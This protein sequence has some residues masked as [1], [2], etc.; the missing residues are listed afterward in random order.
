MKQQPTPDQET[1]ESAKFLTLRVNAEAKALLQRA[2]RRVHAAKFSTGLR[3]LALTAAETPAQYPIPRQAG[4]FARGILEIRIYVSEEEHLQVSTAARQAGYRWTSEWLLDLFGWAVTQGPWASLERPNVG[5][6]SIKELPMSRPAAART[7]LGLV[8][9]LPQNKGGAGKS[10]T[11]TNV[12]AELALLGYESV[13]VDLDPQ[14]D[15]SNSL[16]IETDIEEDGADLDSDLPQR[17]LLTVLVG[18]KPS[19]L[20]LVVPTAW[21]LLH[22]QSG[23]EHT[24]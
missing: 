3:T 22:E 2:V 21:Y 19:L 24:R 18:K 13:L 20:D 5:L 10:T 8:I 4:V 7:P 16:G 6:R 15:L 11:A 1:S 12:G 14:C 17:N 23:V 9:A